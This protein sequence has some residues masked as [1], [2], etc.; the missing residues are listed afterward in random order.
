LVCVS[1]SSR[2]HGAVLGGTNWAVSLLA[3][4]Q[5]PLARHFAHRGRDLVTQFEA[6]EHVPAPHSGAPVLMGALGWLDCVTEAE[7][8][9]GDHTIV[10]GRVLATGRDSMVN[11]PLT[12]YRGA[13]HTPS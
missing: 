13:Y 10:V 8:D 11:A 12:Y 3:A 5:E 1:K 9:A 7:H 2:F 4:D 6:M